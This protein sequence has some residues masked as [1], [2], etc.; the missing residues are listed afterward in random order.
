ML[1]LCFA[2]TKV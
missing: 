1:R 2:C